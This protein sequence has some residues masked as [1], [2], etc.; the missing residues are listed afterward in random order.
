MCLKAVTVEKGVD[1]GCTVGAQTGVAVNRK[2]SGVGAIEELGIGACGLGG[3]NEIVHR[4]NV[5]K[6]VSI[7]IEQKDRTMSIGGMENR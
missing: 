2:M 6:M 4:T 5:A 3:L 7:V 1:H